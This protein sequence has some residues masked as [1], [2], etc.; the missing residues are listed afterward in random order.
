MDTGEGTLTQFFETGR[1]MQE[2]ID[3]I[4][5]DHPH[6]GGIFKVG[7]TI[8][9]RGSKFKI[10]SINA[11]GMRLKLLH[12][13]DNLN[14]CVCPQC[15]QAHDPGLSHDESDGSSADDIS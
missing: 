11:K 14:R 15:G 6:A 4:I 7:E 13:G 10:K 8:W 1:K 12:R 3:R 5:G 9:I 2:S